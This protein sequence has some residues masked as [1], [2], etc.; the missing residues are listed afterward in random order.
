MTRILLTVCVSLCATRKYPHVNILRWFA[1]SCVLPLA[2]SFS[3]D[4][5]T[6]CYTTLE[7]DS[8]NS[9]RKKLIWIQLDQLK[10]L[11][12][13]SQSNT[14]SWKL[15]FKSSVSYPCFWPQNSFFTSQQVSWSLR[16]LKTLHLVRVRRCSVA[17]QWCNDVLLCLDNLGL[18]CQITRLQTII[19]S[20]S[21]YSKESKAFP[22]DWVQQKNAVQLCENMSADI[23]CSKMQS[24][25]NETR[26]KLWASRSKSCPN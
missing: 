22:D 20:Q 21:P 11:D 17:S 8:T 26:G 24:F 15:P 10:L 2:L 3:P 18:V 9:C 13:D 14:S 4:I 6:I 19:I 23:I 12:F 16:I 7:I 1:K 25:R 5:D